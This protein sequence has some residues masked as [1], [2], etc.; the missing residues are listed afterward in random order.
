MLPRDL[1]TRL[2]RERRVTLQ[3][4]FD[5]AHPFAGIVGDGHDVAQ[6]SEGLERASDDR[7]ADGKIFVQLE[8]RH[9]LPPSARIGPKPHSVL[10]SMC[11]SWRGSSRYGLEPRTWTFD[12]RP[13]ARQASRETRCRDGLR[14]DPA[15]EHPMPIR[16]LRGDRLHEAKIDLGIER[17]DIADPRTRNGGDVGRAGGRV[18]RRTASRRRR[19][20]MRASAAPLP[21]KLRARPRRS[22]RSDRRARPAAPRGPA[23]RETSSASSRSCHRRGRRSGNRP[24]RRDA[25][26]IPAGRDRRCG[27]PR[28]AS[29]IAA[30]VRR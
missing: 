29:P 16:P 1:T 6:R 17:P 26:R 4:A 28:C 27:A 9:I 12:M 8:R 2:D 25:A 21:G 30:R 14:V 20:Q 23:A 11:P 15:D 3:R 24:A 5:R 18:L 10:T 7:T 19:W 13:S 22:R